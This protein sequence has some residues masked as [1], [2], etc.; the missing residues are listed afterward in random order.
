M[1]KRIYEESEDTYGDLIVLVLQIV[2][3]RVHVDEVLVQSYA[4][5]D[6]LRQLNLL[7]IVA[8][9]HLIILLTEHAAR[10]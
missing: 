5:Q 2:E 1:Q 7:L 10:C 4:A 6:L 9:R 3:W 8:S